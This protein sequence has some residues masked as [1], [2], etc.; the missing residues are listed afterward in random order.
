MFFSVLLSPL[1]IFTNN[2][3]HVAVTCSGVNP[4]SKF[5]YIAQPTRDHYLHSIHCSYDS[6]YARS[7]VCIW[8]SPLQKLLAGVALPISVFSSQPNRHFRFAAFSSDVNW[9]PVGR[10]CY[11]FSWQTLRLQF[12]LSVQMADE[13]ANCKSNASH[14]NN[15]KVCQLYDLDVV[16]E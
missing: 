14:D 4:R 6:Q 5:Q 12:T 7:M 8:R 1:L 15:R 9:K 13:K 3:P 16:K 11:S 2:G 10:L